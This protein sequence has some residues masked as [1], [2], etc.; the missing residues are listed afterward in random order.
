MSNPKDL[1]IFHSFVSANRHEQAAKRA[2][3]DIFLRA[4]RYFLGAPY[5][6]R[7]LDTSGTEGLIINLRAF[8]CFTLVENCCA[9]AIVRHAGKDHFADYAAILQSLR[10]RDGMI[11]GYSSRLHYFSDW[12][13]NSE[14]V[15]VIRDMTQALGGRSSQKVLNYMTTHS[16]LYPP[17]QDTTACREMIAIERRLSE[18]H[19]YLLP[20]GKISRWEGGI[21][22]GDILAITTDQEGLDVCHVGIAAWLDGRLHLIHASQQAG[23]VVISPETLVDYL[24]QSPHRT[25]VM[26]ARLALPR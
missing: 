22:E 16:E 15:G 7:T 3:G 12:L 13:Q 24:H 5:E 4:G 2:P 10:Y 20:K 23:Q 6:A 17:L 26:T 8:D 11:A 19:R 21:E 18:T 25:G 9:L 1:E 14:G